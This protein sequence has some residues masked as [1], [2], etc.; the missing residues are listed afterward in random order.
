MHR[1]RLSTQTVNISV[2]S[3]CGWLTCLDHTNKVKKKTTL[4]QDLYNKPSHKKK[5]KL[6]ESQIERD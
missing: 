4:V 3:P 2:V 6:P 1:A 5:K